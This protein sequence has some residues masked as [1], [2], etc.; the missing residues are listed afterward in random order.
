[1]EVRQVEGRRTEKEKRR[2]THP[3]FAEFQYNV[4]I[5]TVI[6]ET[7]ELH[8]ILVAQT[9]VDRYFLAHFLLLVVLHH[10]FLGYDFASKNIF[11]SHI[12]DLVAFCESSLKEGN[13]LYWLVEDM[14]KQNERW[15]E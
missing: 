5:E 15:M 4:D 1:M 11:C 8:D 3:L 2:K 6:E 10:Q 14:E 9:P 13:T 7:M 12:D